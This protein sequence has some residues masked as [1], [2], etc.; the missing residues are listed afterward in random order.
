MSSSFEN[1]EFRARKRLAFMDELSFLQKSKGIMDQHHSIETPAE[2]VEFMEPGEFR[3]MQL[4]RPKGPKAKKAKV[5]RRRAISVGEHISFRMSDDLGIDLSMASASEFTTLD[6]EA[7]VLHERVASAP[8]ELTLN[9][10]DLYTI[11]VAN[12]KGWWFATNVITG[13]QG[14]VPSQF[15]ARQE[16]SEMRKR[17]GSARGRKDT[18]QSG[19]RPMVRVQRGPSRTLPKNRSQPKRKKPFSPTS[20]GSGRRSCDVFSSD[21]KPLAIGNS[22]GSPSM[23]LPVRAPAFLLDDRSRQLSQQFSKSSLVRRKTR[24]FSDDIVLDFHDALDSGLQSQFDEPLV[25]LRSVKVDGYEGKIPAVLV[26][27]CTVLENRGGMFEKSI[28]TQLV[29]SDKRPAITKARADLD[30]SGSLPGEL[31]PHL[32]GALLIEWLGGV[33]PR[34]LGELDVKQI[35]KAGSSSRKSGKLLDKLSEPSRSTALYV[36]DFLARI[37]F[38]SV[39]NEM[40]SDGLALVFSPFLMDLQKGSSG[41]IQPKTARVAVDFLVAAIEL[42][43]KAITEERKEAEKGSGK[44]FFRR[45]PEKS[46]ERPQVRL[47]TS[48]SFR[49]KTLQ[50][51][52][53]E[54]VW[55]PCPKD[56]NRAFARKRIV[57]RKKNGRMVVEFEGDREILPKG[58]QFIS[59]EEEDLNRMTNDLTELVHL[60]EPVV[61]YHLGKRFRER[62]IYTRIGSILV[63]VNPYQPLPIYGDDS[64]DR[65]V[66]GDISRIETPHI[67]EVAHRAH[68]TMLQEGRDQSII[69]SGD[70]GAGKTEAA[71]ACLRFLARSSAKSGA[72]LQKIIQ[73]TPILEAFG[74]AATVRNFNSSRFGK[75][76]RILFDNTGRIAGAR[77]TSFLLEKTR[78]VHQ[79]KGER[80]YHIFYQLLRGTNSRVR[81][82]LKLDSI[83]MFRYLNQSDRTSIPDVDDA[84]QFKESVL[85]MKSL[86]FSSKKVNEMFQ[87]LGAI[88][89]IGNIEFR[90]SKDLILKDEASLTTPARLLQVD[91]EKLK[92]ALIFRKLVIRGE[93]T[94]VRLSP[95]EA[96]ENRDALAKLLYQ[97]LFD[98]L[99]T[100]I[101]A[102]MRA[103]TEFESKESS[104]R[105]VAILDVY[106]FEIFQNNSFEQVCINY[107]N[108]KLQQFFNL[109]VFQTEMELYKL[110]KIDF[111]DFVFSDNQATIDLIEKAPTGIFRLLEEAC[112]LPRET[113]LSLLEHLHNI[114]RN[115]TNY[116]SLPKKKHCF[117][118]KHYAGPVTYDITGFLNKNRDTISADI[119]S[120][121]SESEF[122]F[123]S[124]LIKEDVVVDRQATM[125]RKKAVSA[126][127][128]SQL[129]TLMDTLTKTEPQYIRCIKPNDDKH[130][131]IFCEPKV[132]QQL[133]YCGVFEAIRIRKLGYPC[134]MPH[135]EFYA[136]YRELAPGVKFSGHTTSCQDIARSLGLESLKVGKTQ[137]FF[138]EVDRMKLEDIRVQKILGR[139]VKMQA[140]AR[141]HIAR[142]RARILGEARANLHLV[143]SGDD[144]A[145]IK[146]SVSEAS[147]LGLS[148]IYIDEA[149][150]RIQQLKQQEKEREEAR[151]R[152]EEEAR[153]RAEEEARLKAE[154]D[155]LRAEE[156]ARLKPEEEARLRAEE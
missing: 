113:D 67:F 46:I 22:P 99:I 145:A 26:E 114:H 92:S 115:R 37:A 100:R 94:L 78:V 45:K 75:Y 17:A 9:V 7:V 73:S 124:T 138:K 156:E 119:L 134:R 21:I 82:W 19:F 79:S 5:R 128:S 42:R 102:C 153:L 63:S 3:H 25:N 91:P 47:S 68:I 44:S 80:N 10:G 72:V 142:K 29:A 105:S 86:R 15:L 88:L 135:E 126:R 33:K 125:K 148:N 90:Q 143:V 55:A 108:E 89:H 150:F 30:L 136:R 132:L 118:V 51:A 35:K 152:A 57:H 140:L 62:Q 133:N 38:N 39:L 71:K 4:E 59:V 107:A 103:P 84:K 101:N 106:G 83:E 58:V 18:L 109:N 130:P 146:E 96:S 61:L 53:G 13:S 60:N 49:D 122:G 98:S 65:Y 117:E 147:R 56:T 85:A 2:L 14:W 93:T 32:V 40:T 149:K 41:T 87:I 141:A 155:S 139:V 43:L 23:T 64:M 77:N 129:T 12:D 8:N 137:V 31:D 120:C 28:F 123:I 104:L 131:E 48:H 66:A 151:L 6:F 154:E 54:L 52:E 97:R 127:F 24:G 34:V 144:I 69:V 20:P 111:E 110:E 27:I 70:S 116:S 95:E 50:L 11:S 81:E 16:E 74:N 1:M 36:L 121:L 112:R 76:C